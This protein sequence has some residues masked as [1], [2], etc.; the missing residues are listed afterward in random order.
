MTKTLQKSKKSVR[1]A[2][3]IY[4]THYNLH[5]HPDLLSFTYTGNETIKI[6]SDKDIKEITIHSKDLDIETLTPNELE[7]MKAD[8]QQ[9]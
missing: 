2:S 8:W 5:L 1:L 4:P 3:H 7:R 6:F 9:V